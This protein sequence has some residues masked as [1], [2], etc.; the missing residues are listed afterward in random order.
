MAGASFH[1]ELTITPSQGGGHINTTN[2][3]HIFA[4]LVSGTSYNISVETVGV[5]NFTSER[6]QSYLVT[7]SKDFISVPK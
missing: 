4:S 7:T 3:S 2:I 5:M 1:Y 6:V